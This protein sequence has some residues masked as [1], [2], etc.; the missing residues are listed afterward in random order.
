MYL[1]IYFPHVSLLTTVL[2]LIEIEVFLQMSR[3][4][5]RAK[6]LFSAELE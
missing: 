2:T 5:Q 1:S 6:W 3:I 4:S